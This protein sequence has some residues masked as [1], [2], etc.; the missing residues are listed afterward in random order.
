MNP[1]PERPLSNAAPGDSRP[2]AEALLRSGGRF[3][4]VGIVAHPGIRSLALR[5]ADRTEAPV[6]SLPGFEDDE[7]GGLFLSG[8]LA[9]VGV[10]LLDPGP[11]EAAHPFASPRVLRLLSS[12]GVTI[13]LFVGPARPLGGVFGEGDLL[14]IVEIEPSADPDGGGLLFDPAL[15]VLLDA[16]AAEEGCRIAEAVVRGAR[17]DEGGGVGADRPGGREI[18]G[19]WFREGVRPLGADAVRMAALA[20]VAAPTGEAEEGPVAEI[21]ARFVDAVGR[22]PSL[23][24]PLPAAPVD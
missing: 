13:V 22:R 15:G 24:I 19:S 18:T 5:L 2:A 14:R 17:G 20:I 8:R 10:V 3:P 23:L 6:R 9:G 7:S 4:L 21:V 16:A 1:P 12:A 11:V